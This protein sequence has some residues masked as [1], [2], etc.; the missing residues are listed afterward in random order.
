M[1][2]LLNLEGKGHN[3][4]LVPGQPPILNK[5]IKG[6]KLKLERTKRGIQCVHTRKEN[7]GKQRNSRSILE[8]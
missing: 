8:S 1:T 4:C 7:I 6:T 2:L 3:L 5:P